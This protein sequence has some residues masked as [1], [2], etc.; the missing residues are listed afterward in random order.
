M[1]T[2]KYI[3]PQ[4]LILNVNVQTSLLIGS[5]TSANLDGVGIDIDFMETEEELRAR[6]RNWNDSWGNDW[7][8]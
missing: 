2:R 4:M 7:G 3:P 8:D 1:N 6:D 5:I